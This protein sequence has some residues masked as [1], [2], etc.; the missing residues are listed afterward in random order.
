VREVALPLVRILKRETSLGI[1]VCLGTLDLSLYRELREAGAEVY[2]LKFETADPE[3]YERTKLLARSPKE[4][5]TSGCWR[6]RDGL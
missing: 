2:I 6:R 3:D 5:N 1:I 4:S